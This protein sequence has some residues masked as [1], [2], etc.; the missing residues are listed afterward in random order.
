MT[1]IIKETFSLCP[2]CLKK[3]PASLVYKEDGVYMDKGCESH[4]YFSTI[5]WRSSK[6]YYREWMDF[7][8]SRSGC[9]SVI[10]STDRQGCPFDCGLCRGHKQETCSA[11]IMVTKKCNLNCPVCFTRTKTGKQ[12]DP[13]IESIEKMYKFYWETFNMSNRGAF[14][15]ELCGGEPTVRDDLP[16]IVTLGKKIGFDYIQINTNG[17]RIGQ[18]IDYLYALKYSGATTIYLS[19]DGFSDETHQN[20]SGEK[21]TEIKIKAVENCS[22][23]GIGVVLVPCIVPGINKNQVG[24]IIEFAKAHTPTV[25]GVHFQPISYFGD[26]PRLPRNEYRITIPEIIQAIETQTGGQIK[27]RNFMPPGCEHPMCSFMGLF[28][29]GNNGKLEGI[30]KYRPR[31]ENESQSEKVRQFTKRFWKYNS[32]KCLTIGG[33]AFQDVWNVDLERLKNCTIH[34]I[35]PGGKLVPLCAKYLTGTD[36]TKIYPGIS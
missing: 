9:N 31:V 16:D 33:M 30:T 23:V 8:G 36:G 13:D 3:I 11:A 19:F 12:S 24:Q 20:N 1:E 21:L 15:V 28:I 10:H 17:I 7:A 25:R 34:I 18:D 22:E 5:V 26:Y 14:P 6:E 35:N 27:K 2:V 32:F 4:G 29:I